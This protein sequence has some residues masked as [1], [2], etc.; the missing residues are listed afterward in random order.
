MNSTYKKQMQTMHDYIKELE[1]KI[2]ALESNKPIT[3]KA[4]KKNSDQT[5]VILE[6]I[7]KN[8]LLN[9]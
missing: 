7:E 1:L 9:I 5:N 8:Y 4:V 2:K 6:I 3:V